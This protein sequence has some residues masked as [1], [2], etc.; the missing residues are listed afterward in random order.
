MFEAIATV[1][2]DDGPPENPEQEEDSEEIPDGQYVVESIVDH[3]LSR[4]KGKKGQLQYLIKWKNYDHSENTWED[5]SGLHCEKILTDYHAVHP[6]EKTLPGRK[7]GVAKKGFV[8]GGID[9]NKSAGSNG[10]RRSTR[11]HT[12]SENLS[13]EKEDSSVQKE[14]RSKR[15]TGSFQ[16][17]I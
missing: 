14:T 17:L 11:Q 3:R 8:N 2:G 5:E 1:A 10:I 15:F 4:A 12:E 16:V 7:N 13:E 9:H 6:R